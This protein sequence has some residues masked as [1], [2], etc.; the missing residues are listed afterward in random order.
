MRG[1]H[2]DGGDPSESED[3]GR[4]AWIVLE[5][6]LGEWIGH[7]RGLVEALP[8][9]ALR[10]GRAVRVFASTAAPPELVARH[11]VVPLFRLRPLPAWVAGDHAMELARLIQSSQEIAEDLLGRHGPTAGAADLVLLPTAY[12]W[13]ML[14]VASWLRRMPSA[15]RPRLAVLIHEGH[16]L[17]APPGHPPTV[18]QA[19]IMLGVSALTS[20][21]PGHRLLVAATSEELAD[22]TAR[23][24]GR[25]M[26]VVPV[27]NPVGRL[28]PAVPA[29]RR[30]T[31][32]GAIRVAL[33]GV[34]RPGK[35]ARL[36]PAVIA[37]IRS[38]APDAS[39]L[40]QVGAGHAPDIED[41][42]V[43]LR[44]GALSD[45]DYRDMLT[46]AAI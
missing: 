8:E 39:I 46:N 23:A 11:G 44:P 32:S 22:A 40:A 38:A 28:V 15:S 13:L 2:R 6:T 1:S 14:A 5:P 4:G 42:M 20:V 12:P 3:G 27:A 29:E 35:N 25:P 36:L 16:G 26:P 37:A 43:D 45:D 34:P 41:A 10:R 21:V 30:T 9:L 7:Q 31:P 17:F 24:L 19:A 18:D 33:P